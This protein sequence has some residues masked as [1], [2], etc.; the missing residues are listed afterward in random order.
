MRIQVRINDENNTTFTAHNNNFNKMWDDSRGFMNSRSY[1]TQKGFITAIKKVL[2]E[3]STIMAW[4][5]DGTPNK[6]F[7]L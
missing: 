2:T 5:E 6:E 3:D 7:T 4:N 1:K